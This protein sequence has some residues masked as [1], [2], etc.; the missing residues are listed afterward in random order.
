[1]ST[2]GPVD[3]P[4]AAQQ[5]HAC[6]EIIVDFYM[7]KTTVISGIFRLTLDINKVQWYQSFQQK[8]APKAGH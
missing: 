8:G 7:N 5:I 2:L 1:M 4:V 3:L 6:S